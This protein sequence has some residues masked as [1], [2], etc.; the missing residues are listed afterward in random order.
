MSLC[1]YVSRNVSLD[2]CVQ[3]YGDTSHSNECIAQLLLNH[4]ATASMLPLQTPFM[5][6]SPQRCAE[7]L[8][9]QE[10]APTGRLEE[11]FRVQAGMPNF[12]PQQIE[13]IISPGCQ[14]LPSEP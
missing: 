11:P 4:I 5:P 9:N 1:L 7:T 6:M 14:T 12:E 3:R 2:L 13:N 10:T 8:G